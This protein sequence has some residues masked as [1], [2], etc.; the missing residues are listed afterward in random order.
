MEINSI[1]KR[2]SAL[3]ALKK[4]VSEEVKKDKK[5]L[6]DNYNIVY[7]P[8]QKFL[9]QQKPEVNQVRADYLTLRNQVADTNFFKSIKPMLDQI[10]ESNGTR[11]YGQISAN[12]GIICD[13]FLFN[14][15][16]GIAN[17]IYIQRG[18][19]K[20]VK[21]K[22]DVLLVVTTWKGLNMEWKGLGNPNIRKHRKELEDIIEFYRNQGTKI[23]F[24]SKED[25]VNYEVFLGIAQK[26]DYIFTTAEEKIADYK[27]DCNNDNVYLLNFGINPTYHNPIGLRKFAKR[28]EVLFT[29]SWYE[30]Y[31]DRQKETRVLF[32]GVLNGGRDLKI[33]DRNYD[34]KLEAY[35]FPE[36]YLQ[37]VSPAVNHHYLQKLHK[38]FDWSINLNSVKY[39]NTMFA[40]RIYELQAL[41]NILLSNY[42]IGVNN[43]FP[44]VFMIN[45]E[46]EI[47]SI[48]DSFT[49]E[50]LYQHQVL[51]IR[52][53]MSKETSYHRIEEMLETIG[54]SFEKKD[55][56][57]AVI[58][59]EETDS[60]HSVFKNQTYPLKDL[61][62]E[63][64][65][66]EDLLIGYDIITFFDNN[67]EY[68][69]FYLEDMI[70]AFKF[71]DCD[72]IT[73]DAFYD[74]DQ[75]N[76]GI[77]HDYV[78]VIKDKSCTV[79]WA[80]S[81]NLSELIEMEVPINKANGFSIDRF[82]FNN[83]KTITKDSGQK[84]YKLSVIV[85]AYNNGDHLLNKCFNSLKRSSLFED[86]E[87]VIVDDGSTDNYTPKVIKRLERE[88]ENVKTFFYQDGG[89]GSASRPR[90][91]GVK[92]AAAEYVTYLDPD[93]E[94]IN[95]GYW[96]LYKELQENS[97]D[98]V[99]GNMVR[100]DDKELLFDYYKTAMQYNGSSV[101]SGNVNN[102]LVNSQF[103]AMSIQALIVRKDVIIKN[104][105]EM[106]EGAAGQDTLF[107]QELLLNSKRTKAIDLPIHIYYAAVAGSTVNTITKRFFE[108]YYLLEKVRVEVLRKHDL[109]S[110][111]MEKRFTYY[112]K[113]WYLAKLKNVIIEDAS[114]SIEI[115]GEI[116]ALYE[117][118][119][120]V[121]DETIWRFRELINQQKF[122]EIQQEFIERK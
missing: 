39:S 104:L 109:L 89:S 115:L 32:D 64:D 6:L 74:R 76:E 110:D 87:I 31:P 41:G 113:N 92:L 106:V 11:F 72:Y 120:S 118:S 88:Y 122:D 47:K 117:N 66:N 91:N 90:N 30:K 103:K 25:P 48:F 18:N 67:K 108:K 27:K 102:Y 121:E 94:A 71:T 56:K 45:N 10:P 22:L 49:E 105:L 40:N 98:M 84:E 60:L 28:Q 80:D 52:R 85:P 82:E 8:N 68:G 93:N 46:N 100:L 86:M 33:V 16:K 101:I 58:I 79:F 21:E 78:D 62:V 7:Q 14:S 17:F 37:Y 50:E 63:K 70:N 26:C 29:G 69:E 12:I 54:I 65:I 95:D 24:Y 35:F 77:E 83:Q 20:A 42:S 13:E 19:Y 99:V 3:K 4:K 36:E 114:K 38:L 97:Y 59:K 111:F 81:F 96:N 61:F 75:F 51:G 23:V 55:R 44:N 15:Y 116:F 9:E 119:I 43:K 53:V 2:L 112:F 57:V 34:L 73:K 107:F 1:E 5:L